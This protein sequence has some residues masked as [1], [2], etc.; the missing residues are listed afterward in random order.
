ML[1][2]SHLAALDKL[3]AHSLS[4]I[5]QS[6]SGCVSYAQDKL[7]IS[8]ALDQVINAQARHVT[9]VVVSAGRQNERGRREDD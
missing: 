6:A 9:L 3:T 4:A 1:G 7:F 5:I 8:D 2:R